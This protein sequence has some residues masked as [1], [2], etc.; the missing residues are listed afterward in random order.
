MALTIRKWDAKTSQA[1]N[2]SNRVGNR[3]VW[4]EILAKKGDEFVR[5]LDVCPARCLDMAKALHDEGHLVTG[6]YAYHTPVRGF[7]AYEEAGPWLT[8]AQIRGLTTGVAS[9]RDQ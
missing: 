4:M 3:Y 8:N 6:V 9:L 2:K 5:Y 1:F 7:N